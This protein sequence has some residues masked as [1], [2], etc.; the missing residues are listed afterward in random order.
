MKTSIVVLLFNVHRIAEIIDQCSLEFTLS[1][2]CKVPDHSPLTLHYQPNCIYLPEFDPNDLDSPVATGVSKIYQYHTMSPEFLKSDTWVVV[3]D[4]L[5][6]RLEQMDPLQCG[7]DSLYEKM[8][9]EIIL[10]MDK[11]INYR[12]GKTYTQEI[13]KKLTLA[14]KAMSAA[15]REFRKCR[16]EPSKEK[17]LRDLFL[18]RRKIIW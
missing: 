10:E 5:L 15:E 1:E 11:Y 17:T 4:T 3:L 16:Y 2:R 9:S 12:H 14:W 8:T 13:Y 6:M 18:K 7:L